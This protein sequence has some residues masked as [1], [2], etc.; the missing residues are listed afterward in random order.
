MLRA[1]IISLVIALVGL[2]GIAGMLIYDMRT[3][4]TGGLSEPLAS[5]G[6]PFILT[7]TDGQPFDI[8]SLA[9]KPFVVFFGFT[10]CP[11]VCPTTLNDLTLAFNALGEKA[12]DLRAVFVTVDP[13]RDR[14]EV[15]KEYL[16]SFDARILALTGSVDDIAKV[17][18]LYRVYYAKQPTSDGSYTMDHTSLVYLMNRDGKFVGTLDFHEDEQIRV[19]KLEKLVQTSPSS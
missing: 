13:E 4:D 2:L 1:P 12:R 19:K 5:I 3:R 18:K 14:P 8:A 9:G 15:L 6:G 17:A 11:E 16:S 10:H 7:G